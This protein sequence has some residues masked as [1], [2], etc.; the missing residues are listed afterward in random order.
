MKVLL[1]DIKVADGHMKEFMALMKA[2]ARNSLAQ[3]KGCLQFDICLSEEDSQSVLLYE[4]YENGEAFDEHLK[5]EYF[6]EFDAVTA[7]MIVWK[8]L[9]LLDLVTLRD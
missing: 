2:Q 1:V 7:Q 9:R 3:E 8:S 6:Q 5:T 4:V